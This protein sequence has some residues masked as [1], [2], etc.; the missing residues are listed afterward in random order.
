MG[1]Q[2]LICHRCYFA[3]CSHYREK[4]KKESWD[5]F[6]HQSTTCLGN[7]CCHPGSSGERV[8]QGEL[9]TNFSRAWRSLCHWASGSLGSRGCSRLALHLKVGLKLPLRR[10]QRGLRWGIEGRWGI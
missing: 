8:P 7:P 4:L 9:E 5:S 6:E 10:E 3:N 1:Y 2:M